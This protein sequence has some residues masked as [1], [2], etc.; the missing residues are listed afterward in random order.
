MATVGW[1]R[2]LQ[3]SWTFSMWPDPEPK[4]TRVKIL[5]DRNAAGRKNRLYEKVEI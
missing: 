2:L 1:A 3:E 4:C 5:G